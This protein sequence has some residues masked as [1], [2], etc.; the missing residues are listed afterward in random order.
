MNRGKAADIHGVTAEHFIHG[1]DALID[2]TVGI[3]NSLYRVGEL[4]DCMK[5]GVIT[6]IYKKKGSA[7]DAKN[8][9]GITILPIVTKILETVLREVVRPAVDEVQSGLQRG[10]TQNSSPMN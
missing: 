3:I 9:R 7:T 2:T 1:G 5:V 4:T 6:P 8:Y 10:F